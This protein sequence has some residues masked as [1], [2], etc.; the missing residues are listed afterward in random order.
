MMNRAQILRLL[1][2]GVT[3]LLVGCMLLISA[4]GL[5]RLRTEAIANGLETA[6]MHS[7]GFE[8]LFTQSLRLAAVITAGNLENERPRSDPLHV[9]ET[10]GATL[11]HAPFLRS[12]SLL[13]DEG[14]VTASSNLANIGLAVPIDGFLPPPT[15]EL[16]VMSIGAPWAGRDLFRGR[17]STPEEPAA[18]DDLSFVPI[19]QKVAT[20]EGPA[21]L[22]I[23]LNPDY[24]VNHFSQKL[25]SPEG[26]VEILRYDGTL[27][28]TTAA[29]GR[30]GQLQEDAIHRFSLADEEFGEFEQDATGSDLPRPTL[31]SFR[32]SRL[33]P[34]VVV[35]RIDREYALRNWKTASITLLSVALPVLLGLTLLSV[36]YY[37]RQMLTAA[38]REESARLK[39]INATVFD[40]STE[41]TLITDLDAAIVS[42]NAAFTRVTG[43]A[44][45]EVIGRPLYTFLTTEGT[46]ALHEDLPQHGADGALGTTPGEPLAVEVQLRCKDGSLVWMEILLTPEHD[47]SGRIVGYRR[48]GRNIT[49]RRE[50]QDRVRE[51]AFHDPLTGLPNR[52]L[53]NDRLGLAMAQSKR[54][55]MYGAVLF[56]DLD[57]FKPLNDEHG[58]G[59]GDLLLIEVADRLRDCVREIDTVARFGGDEFVV[60]LGALQTTRNESLALAHN[61]AQKISAVLSS[62]YYLAVR[63]HDGSEIAIE[64]TCTSS[65]GGALY[66]DNEARHEEVLKRADS[67]MYR[68]KN[69]GRNRIR[70]AGIED[71]ETVLAD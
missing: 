33:Y 26:T 30:T 71:I 21:T 43:Y 54:S 44:A 6:A 11:R 7:R 66:F 40:S 50:M 34:V 37:R 29:D 22:L 24:F 5:W 45:L 48:I 9:A 70:F 62:P 42:I 52:R 20:R 12:L 63:R 38:Q 35:T 3:L 32:A 65:I 18:T 68:A 36:A 53:L 14:R 56:L 58:H 27:L 55:G 41:A 59:A 4:F 1:L 13:N 60:V 57:N 16:G 51:L 17:P 23:A 47:T 61:V 46:V 49:E 31:T 64:H 2:L 25:D 69:D 15:D 19:L 10:F 39:A 8:D 67:A 28:M